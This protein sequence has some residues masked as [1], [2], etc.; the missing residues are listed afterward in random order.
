MN[1]NNVFSI[2]TTQ[3]RAGW[4]RP[5]E[6]SLWLVSP[7]LSPGFHLVASAAF[8]LLFCLTKQNNKARNRSSHQYSGQVLVVSMLLFL[9]SCCAVII[10]IVTRFLRAHVVYAQKTKFFHTI[11]SDEKVSPTRFLRVHM[12]GPGTKCRCASCSQLPD[13]C[14]Y[15]FML[16]Y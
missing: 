16:L 3:H 7:L 13:D 14:T 2:G 9:F 4:V 12:F 6:F 5:K 15:I 10:W 11:R 8:V 1:M